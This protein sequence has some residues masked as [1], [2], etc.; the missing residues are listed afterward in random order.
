MGAQYNDGGDFDYSREL[1]I[2]W[3]ELTNFPIGFDDE[4]RTALIDA[5]EDLSLRSLTSTVGAWIQRLVTAVADPSLRDAA[6]D[7]L[8][9]IGTLSE[10]FLIPQPAEDEEEH[11]NF[12]WP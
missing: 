10:R 7:N 2:R 8:A 4:E 12:F 6:A 1:L 9:F 5:I 11:N 3:S